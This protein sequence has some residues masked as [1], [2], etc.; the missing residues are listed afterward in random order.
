M[1]L[2]DDEDGDGVD[3][4]VF[5]DEHGVRGAPSDTSADELGGTREAKTESATPQIP[6]S[7]TGS[8]AERLED[9]PEGALRRDAATSAVMA[10]CRV[11]VRVELIP[12][13]LRVPLL[14]PTS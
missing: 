14:L 13:L 2:L 3:N 4:V 9:A 10:P 12:P 1:L 7:V 11:V 8:P 6:P 5:D